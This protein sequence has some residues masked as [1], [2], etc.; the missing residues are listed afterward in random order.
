VLIGIAGAI[1][2][3]KS[4]IA[5]RLAEQYGFRVVA[6]ADGLREEIL[7][8]LPLTLNELH[9][10]QGVAAT[11]WCICSVSDRDPSSACIRK[12]LYEVKPPGVR[13]LLQEYGSDVRRADDP[14][15]WVKRWAQSVSNIVNGRPVGECHVVSPDC[16]FPNEARAVKAMGGQLWRVERPGCVG[17]G[18]VSET[19]LA[20]WFDYDAVLV[21]DGTLVDLYVE[22]E[23]RLRPR[24][25]AQGDGAWL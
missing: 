13:Q 9:E 5:E 20:H 14:D 2:A 23:Q 6:F 24:A 17:T 21:N 7:T 8:R 15:Y 19:A 18:H 25:I 3:G 11:E 10:L 1:G 4:A 16:R 12:M 22:I